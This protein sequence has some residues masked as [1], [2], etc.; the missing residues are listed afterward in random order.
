LSVGSDGLSDVRI[1]MGRGLAI[2]G[3]ALDAAG[4]SAAGQMIVAI[5]GDGF[6]R[7]GV[8]ADGSFRIEGL[9]PG[10]YALSVGSTLA[11]FATRPSVMP[12][13]EEVTLVL[14]PAGKVALHVVS[15]DGRPVGEAFASVSVVDGA[16]VDLRGSIA[17][18]TREDGS[19]EI[20]CPAGEIGIA[21]MSEQGSG[22]A[23]IAL[24]SGETVPLRIVVQ[25][26]PAP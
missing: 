9:G 20:G 2:V 4:R 25:P 5:G 3:R 14:R 7:T 8:R 11:G 15:P 24:R 17:P 23:T 16:P 22:F 13:S 1:E 6:E 26:N 19:I 12:G 18:P 21:V 10:P